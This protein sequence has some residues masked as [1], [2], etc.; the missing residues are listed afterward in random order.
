LFV[1]STVNTS[2]QV[3]QCSDVVRDFAEVDASV[4]FFQFLPLFS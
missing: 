4:S 3:E 1:A 2:V